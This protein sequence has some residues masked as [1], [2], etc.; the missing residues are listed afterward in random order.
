MTN[1]QLPHGA[2]Q[3]DGFPNHYA[4]PDGRVYSSNIQRFC[5]TQ[6]LNSGYLGVCLT[7][8]GVKR[9]R[10]V[11]RVIAETFVS[12]PDGKN[13]VNHL[14]GNKMNNDVSN[15]QWCTHSENM[16][17]GFANGL[18]DNSRRAAAVRMREIGK[19]FADVNGQRLRELNQIASVP[20][21]Q[22]T[23]SGEFVAEY[24]S[25]KEAER[26][27]RAGNINKV[28]SGQYKQSGGFL[29]KRK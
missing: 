29:W 17:H 3:I 9:L 8:K 14:D 18:F 5:S 6:L 4:L 20:V 15:L 2:K 1:I 27:T 24:P 23:I 7:F 16:Q 12:K 21:I 13:Y 28:I 25:V 11:H 19:Q 22:L 10:T 26:Q